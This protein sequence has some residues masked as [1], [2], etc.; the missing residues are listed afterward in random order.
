MNTTYHGPLKLIRSNSPEYNVDGPVP[1]Y[2][3]KVNE[4]LFSM[5]IF[6]NVFDFFLNHC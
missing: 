6:F 5:N 4:F 2:N 1:E 3:E